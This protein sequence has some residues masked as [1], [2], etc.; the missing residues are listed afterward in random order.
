MGS[1]VGVDA[2]VWCRPSSD[3]PCCSDS[4]KGICISEQDCILP[5]SVNLATYVHAEVSD[6]ILQDKTSV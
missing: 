1:F 3:K 5:N 6:W 4:S 2:S